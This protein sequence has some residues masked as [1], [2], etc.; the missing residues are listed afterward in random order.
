MRPSFRKRGY[1]SE[2]TAL[3]ADFRARSP[4]CILCWSVGVRRRTEIIDHKVPVVDAPDRLL[5][6]SNLQACCRDCHDRCKRIIEAR[7][8]AG[9][10]TT[11]DLDL[12]SDVAHALRRK[13][14]RPMI[15]ADGY[16]EV[17]EKI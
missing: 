15:G 4:W 10:A 9:T 8:R 5:D 6:P 7:W 12:R 2:W 1:N 16:E 13:L 3:A 11:E 17:D 14:H